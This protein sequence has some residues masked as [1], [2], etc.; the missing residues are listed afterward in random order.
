M[1]I[2]SSISADVLNDYIALKHGDSGVDRSDPRTW[3]YYLNISGR[4]HPID[5]LMVV[6]SLDTLEEIAFTVE[7]LR[8]H[9]ATAQ[10]YGYGSRYYYSLLSRYPEQEQLILGVLYPVDLDQAI[11]AENGTVLGYPS[12]LVEPQEQ[13][14]IM[15][16]QE[17]IKRHHVRWNVQAFGVS[18]SLYN[19]SYHAQLYLALLPKFLNL[20]LRRAKTSEAHSFHVREYLASNTGLDKYLRFMTT[21]QALYF[22]RNLN[23]IERNSGKAHIARELIQKILSDRR[24][25]L[26]EYSVRQLS[27]FDE[28]H[29]PLINARRKPI[30]DQFN[31][32]E[33]S[34]I[35][36]DDLYDKEKT[37]TYGTGAFYDGEKP[38]VDKKFQTSISSV[39]QTKNLESNMV[40]YN[41]AVPDT[42]EEVLLRQWAHLST[43]GLYNV[44]INF[45]DPKSSEMRSL[46]A[47]DALIYMLYL[48]LGS[49]SIHIDDLPLYLNLKY[50]RHP[51]PTLEDLMSVVDHSIPHIEERVFDVWSTQPVIA[52]S[53]ST[54]AFFN[55]S[56]TLYDQSK[57][58]WYMLSNTHDLDLRGALNAVINRL[59]ANKL[60]DLKQSGVDMQTWLFQRNLPVY[61]YTYEQATEFIKHLTT[62][63]TGLVID[64]TRQLKN[65]QRAML[66]MMTDLSSYSVQFIKE[67]NDSGIVPLNWAAI[68][69][70]NVK[71]SSDAD[72]MLPFNV[73]VTEAHAQ[74]VI[75]SH[76]ET[77]HTEVNKI[78]RQSEHQLSITTV[79][80]GL[81]SFTDHRNFDVTFPSYTLSASYP[82]S[83]PVIT[84]KAG[85]IG[86]EHYLSLTDEQKSQ[87][88]S[89]YN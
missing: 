52:Q 29:Y 42:L 44:I 34:Y 16:L 2:K 73:R 50:R 86:K 67:I 51:K 83:D 53:F 8:T 68:R 9:T 49:I 57:R 56:Y 14:L 84:S 15:E 33:R 78:S 28:N 48:H 3:K 5:T 74:T 7:N 30:N 12:L 81:Y 88:V 36:I 26:A 40:D 72:L 62:E 43:E 27:S 87:L 31:V 39:I 59:Y 24:I 89:I 54:L 76:I 61:D 37:L 85:Y 58:H 75:G 79:T 18:D 65:L 41:D 10:A 1:V 22:Y 47:K 11:Q 20:R 6:T 32:A 55:Q 23:Y 82:G 64:E 60:I 71:Q 17:F 46:T 69:I 45:K 66:D 70:G 21:K 38:K 25:P 19:V 80:T 4:R 35:E 13:T 63:A 77:K